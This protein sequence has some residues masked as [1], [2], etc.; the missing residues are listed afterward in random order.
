MFNEAEY[1]TVWMIYLAAAACCWL[2]WTQLTRWI[3]WW[4]VR[5]PLWLV[6]AVILFTPATMDPMASWMAPAALGW[7]LETTLGA[8][9]DTSTLLA[10][11]TLAM[12]LA[13]LAYAG[14]VCLRLGWRF[15]RKGSGD[16][17]A[18]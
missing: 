3:G 17:S 8:G 9:G 7:L 14:F 11:L 18:A 2:A 1:Q 6:M 4:F 16:N 12:A 15:W 13:A 5:E 10:Q